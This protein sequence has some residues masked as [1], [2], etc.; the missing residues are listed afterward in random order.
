[1]ELLSQPTLIRVCVQA[2]HCGL[3]AAQSDGLILGFVSPPT[4][5]WCQFF[6]G[7]KLN[8]GWNV[9][10]HLVHLSEGHILEGEKRHIQCNY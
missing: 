7:S 10:H 2:R 3:H 8:C 6:Q 9:D 4:G 1:M 5:I